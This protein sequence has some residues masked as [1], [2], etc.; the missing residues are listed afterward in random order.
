MCVW[1]NTNN[2]YIIII[3]IIIIIIKYYVCCYCCSSVVDVIS[4]VWTFILL[5]RLLNI[6]Q[7]Q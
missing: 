7:Q 1:C 6:Y 3:I 5:M 2:S 4:F